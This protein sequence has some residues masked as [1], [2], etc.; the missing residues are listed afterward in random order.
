MITGPHH[1]DVK[2]AVLT[3]C[4]PGEHA[5]RLIGTRKLCDDAPVSV[6]DQ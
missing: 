3:E 5:R 4:Q 2:I 6:I 1:A